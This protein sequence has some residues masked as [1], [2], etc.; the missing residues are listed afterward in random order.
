MC[1]QNSTFQGKGMEG[2]G[3]SAWEEAHGEEG[4]DL[5]QGTPWGEERAC[6]LRHRWERRRANLATPQVRM[7]LGRCKLV[8]GRK[9]TGLPRQPLIYLFPPSPF[10]PL[11]AGATVVLKSKFSAGQF[12]EDCQKHRVTVFQYIG[13]LCRYLV[14]QPP[15]RGL[16]C[17][18]RGGGPAKAGRW[19]VT[20]RHR[21]R[22]LGVGVREGSLERQDI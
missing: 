2:L 20:R 11:L 16:R 17:W 21:D 6:P 3:V 10:S 19:A 22:C 5:G 8:S 12:W 14:N 1:S 7:L 13:E 4:C 15:V 9:G 18:G